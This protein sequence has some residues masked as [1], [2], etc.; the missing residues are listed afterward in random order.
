MQNNSKMLD[1]RASPWHEVN[2]LPLTLIFFLF[3]LIWIWETL[4][5]EV[6]L[7]TTLKWDYITKSIRQ[8]EEYTCV[9]TL[10]SIFALFYNHYL[11][12]GFCFVLCKSTTFNHHPS[13]GRHTNKHK[14]LK[15]IVLLFSGVCSSSSSSSSLHFLQS[16][17]IT[18]KHNVHL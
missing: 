1:D 8:N 7:H 10:Q 13:L 6:Q 5:Q 4:Y 3:Q 12:D 17:N 9:I 14:L 15:T 2:I 16:P 18:V 11:F